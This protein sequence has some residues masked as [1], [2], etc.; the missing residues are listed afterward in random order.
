MRD[1]DADRRLDTMFTGTNAVQMGQRRNHAD[2]AMST[3]AQ[4]PSAIE[5]NEARYARRINWRAQQ[6]ADERIRATR[7]IHHRAAKVVVIIFEPLATIY[8]RIV[9]EVW[10]TADDHTRGLTAGV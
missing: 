1:D 10:P 6:C 7:V 8:E 3:H 2:R 4:I 9:A 5:K